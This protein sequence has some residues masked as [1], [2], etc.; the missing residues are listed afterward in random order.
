MN[1]YCPI[2]EQ[3]HKSFSKGSE[4]QVWN[5]HTSGAIDLFDLMKNTSNLEHLE[6]NITRPVDLIFSPSDL[7][8][9]TGCWSYYYVTF[10]LA[11][12][13]AMSSTC[14][15]PLLYGWLNL[16]FRTEFA[17]LVTGLRGSDIEMKFVSLYFIIWKFCWIG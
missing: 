2:I 3:I 7:I 6:T 16:Q 5:F 14:Y 1:S 4:K 13:I 17:R 11:H 15:N 10:F 8:L 9:L 12:I